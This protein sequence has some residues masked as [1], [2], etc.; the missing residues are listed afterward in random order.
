MKVITTHFMTSTI[1]ADIKTKPTLKDL[2]NVLREVTNIHGLGI[3]LEVPSAN[4]R[5][6]EANYPQNLERQRIELAEFWL[7][8]QV[9]ASWNLLAE[10]LHNNGDVSLSAKIKKTYLPGLYACV[11][12]TYKELDR[13]AKAIQ[14]RYGY[15]SIQE[16]QQLFD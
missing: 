14:A 15:G 7:R 10:A 12:V 11:C 1:H 8:T 3:Q 9:N 5:E 2:V 6:F 4:L 13:R 16:G